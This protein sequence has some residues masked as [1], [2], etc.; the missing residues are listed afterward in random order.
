MKILLTGASGFVGGAVL[1][2]MRQRNVA[3]RPVFRSQALVL[4]AECTADEAVVVPTLDGS[5]EWTQAL[6]GV[7]V[8]VHCA[9]RAHVMRDEAVDPLAEYR[10]VNVGGTLHLARQAAA[11][12]VQRFVFISSI[13]VNGE[14]TQV[15][16]SYV[17][18]DVPAPEDAYGV[19]KA[20]AEAGLRALANETGMALVIIRPVL[21]YGPGVK[22]N[23]LSMVRW[24]VRGVPLP[25]GAVTG[26][27]R[28]LV[29]LD[30]LVD[31]IVRCTDHPQ[32]ANQIFL[33][34]DGEDLS[35]AD[36]L[37]RICLAQGVKTRLLAVPVWLL[38]LA[39]RLMGRG[40]VA[41]RLLGSLQVDISKTQEVLGW[42]P[43]LSV[44]E[45][46]KKIAEHES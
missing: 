44:D 19:S 16:R 35:T 42:Q 31:L 15:G 46:L 40:A 22:G 17:A 5:T 3:V 12:G 34:S 27:R 4:A 24:V 8:V 30:N 21:V 45:G 11:A 43:P 37:R 13:K 32:A 25:L 26:N 14:T 9:A 6:A 10:R 23:F 29:A 20:E 18:D 1:Q 7:D 38:S 2:A 39:A 36:L 33:A 41:Q 28:S